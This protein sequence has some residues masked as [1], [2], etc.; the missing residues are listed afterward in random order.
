M[1]R[2]AALLGSGASV[3]VFGLLGFTACS[4]TASVAVPPTATVPATAGCG[5]NAPFP[6]T[7]LVYADPAHQQGQCRFKLGTN[8]AAYVEM[9]NV[10]PTGAYVMS[11]QSSGTHPFCAYMSPSGHRALPR[12]GSGVLCDPYP[13][14]VGGAA[15]PG[16]NV[17]FAWA[18]RP[19]LPAG[20]YNIYVYDQSGNGGAG[21][22]LG[23]IQV[24]LT[25]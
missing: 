11:V 4:S 19:S 8:A 21:A 17:S 12:P 14:N 20:T 5:S 7:P 22:V 3:V 18:F 2:F 6:F 13:K 23:S 15:A 24:S 25:R 10:S 16:G 1:M 9:Q